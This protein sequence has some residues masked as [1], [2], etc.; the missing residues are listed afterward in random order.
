MVQFVL[1]GSRATTLACLGGRMTYFEIWLWKQ[2]WLTSLNHSSLINLFS[3]LYLQRSTLQYLQNQSTCYTKYAHWP[4]TQASYIHCRFG[5]DQIKTSTGS[6]RQPNTISI[7]RWHHIYHESDG[8]WS[9]VSLTKVRL[10]P[11]W[12]AGS[13]SSEIVWTMTFLNHVNP[14]TC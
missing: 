14:W 8:T 6:V 13:K 2:K 10:V 1:D 11:G 4:S 7:P 5:N 12:G 3:E 9:W